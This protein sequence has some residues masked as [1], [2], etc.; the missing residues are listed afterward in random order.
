MLFFEET[1][2]SDLVGVDLKNIG[3]DFLDG[4]T[5]LFDDGGH[6]RAPPFSGMGKATKLP[7]TLGAGRGGDNPRVH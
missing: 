3:D 7:L 2:L 1:G 6:Y 5:T 4:F